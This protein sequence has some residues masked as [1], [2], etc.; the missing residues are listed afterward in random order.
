MLA[1]RELATIRAA[2]AY[3]RD[4][5]TPHETEAQAPYFDQVRPEPM[6]E[7]EIDQLRARL[8]PDVVEYAR[9][10]GA[11]SLRLLSR[12]EAVAAASEGENVLLVVAPSD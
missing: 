10:V 3:W 6:S 11:R 1:D 9:I 4:E 8:H 12:Q 7:T 2:L 5:M